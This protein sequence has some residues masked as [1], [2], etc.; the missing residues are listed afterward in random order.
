ME[1]V[2]QDAAYLGL[3][4]LLFLMTVGFLKACVALRG[5]T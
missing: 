2:Y 1:F 4:A 5:R 3:A